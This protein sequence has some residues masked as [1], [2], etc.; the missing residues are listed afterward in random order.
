M[1]DGSATQAPDLTEGL[2]EE[3]RAAVTHPAGPLLVL[4]GA[5]TGKTT[6][7][8]ARLVW[9]VSQG[10]PAERIV[11]LTFTR[12]AAREMLTRAQA[13]LGSNA[14]G[15]VVGGTF[16]SVGYR[17]IAA[18]AATL[19]LPPGFGVLDAADAADLLDLLRE[20]HGLA[21]GKE[22]FPRK[23]T[24]ASIY[25]RCVN[26]QQPLSEVLTEQFPWCE[27]HLDAVAGLFRAYEQRKRDLGRLDLD[28]L[29][30]YSHA[31]AR[32]ELIGRKLGQRFDH[33]LVDEYQDLNRLQVEILRD[34]RR[35]PRGLTAVGDD[36]QAIYG[37]RAASADHV[38]RF[39][40]DFPDAAMVTLDRNYRSTQPILDLANEVWA[41]ATRSY[42]KRLHAD[43]EGGAQPQLVHCLDQA[44]Q[45]TEVCDRV[46]VAHEEGTALREQAVLMRAGRHSN[47]L[48]LE[49]ARRKIPFRKYGGISYMEAA[50][51]KDFLAALRIADNPADEFSW[52]RLLQLAPG[53]GPATARRALDN[54]KPN[55]LASTSELLERWQTEV[56]PLLKP[57]AR[58][59]CG[60][61][62]EALAATD[63]ER[64]V[65]ALT[66]RIC[67]AIKPLITAHYPDWNAR[68][69]DL[70]ALAAAAGDAATLSGFL[71]ELALDPPASSADYAKAPH[72]DEDYLTLST[73]H[74]AKGLEW[75]S[76][77][78]I[79]ASD[80]NF[81]S[82]MALTT[83]EGLEEE[84]RLFYV[85]L[86]R[87]R[88]TL[89][90]YAPLRYYHRPTGNDDAHGY[91]KT[92]RFLTDRAAELCEQI[93]LHLAAPAPPDLGHESQTIKVEVNLDQLWH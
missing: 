93:H 6:T 23:D 72:L 19:G 38:L 59:A 66:E 60:P 26:A 51:V 35:E 54:L 15:R 48:E 89:T 17:L 33:I 16:H 58:Q 32:N 40:D 1:F 71:A 82:D 73:V 47:E 44:Q 7:L 88:R 87:A 75:D 27:H 49:L 42:P 61:L 18:H 13:L 69:P 64:R 20:E 28:D 36:A 76:V 78:V 55:T 70:Q 31:L 39:R 37:F 92:S 12:R 68:L 2:N 4:A 91:G 81:P 50:H 9:L 80:G 52:F 79:S 11:L 74:S 21:A 22:R 84:R 3:Q 8:V 62:I 34:L 25:S 45:A 41:A 77:H 67:E 5:G 85:A 43:H 90:I 65:G 30:V 29:L 24:L 86:T 56:E 57:S 10:I 46:L 14:P 53:I 83:P 63:G